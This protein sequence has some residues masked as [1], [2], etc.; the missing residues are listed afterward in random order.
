MP[1]PLIVL[2][3]LLLTLIALLAVRIRVVVCADNAHCS[4]QLRILFLR[5]RLFPRRK[6]L[7]PLSPGALKRKQAKEAK[8]AAKKQRKKEKKKAQH[9]AKTPRTLREKIRFVRALAAA[10]FRR[11]H[12]HLRLHAARL[13]ILIATD[14]AA[15]TAVAY[16]AVAQS[17]SYLLALFDKITHLRAPDVALVPD[18]TQ[19]HSE[20]DLHVVLSIR[21]FG[22]LAVAFGTVFSLLKSKMSHPKH[23]KKKK[24]SSKNA[25]SKKGN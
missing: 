1:T 20:F 6:R 14:D 7:R 17:V 19:E 2:G 5:F 25:L 3:A 8:K 16:G 10:I 18:F 12:K 9:K 4:V 21:L 11:T 24:H 15:T 23:Q 22:V 13:H